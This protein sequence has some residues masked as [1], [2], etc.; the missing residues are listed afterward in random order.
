VKAGDL[1]RTTRA[2]IGVPAGAIGLI[3][4]THEPRADGASY[5][6]HELRLMAI[7]SAVKYRRFLSK[8]LEV[9]NESR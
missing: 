1:V 3:I 6:I 4:E 8:D 5:K 7:K 9:V 2:S